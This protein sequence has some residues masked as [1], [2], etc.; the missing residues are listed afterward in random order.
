MPTSA[1]PPSSPPNSTASVNENAS[2]TY[3]VRPRATTAAATLPTPSARS[4][5]STMKA[6]M[7]FTGFAAQA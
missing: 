5:D 7:F 6:L 1:P 3:T 4:P 2:A